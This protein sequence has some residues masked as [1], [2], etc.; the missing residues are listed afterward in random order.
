MEVRTLTESDVGI[1]WDL[2]LRALKEEPAAF[3]TSYT[4]AKQRSLESVAERLRSEANTPDSFTLG[5]FP[6]EQIAGM[7]G[8][9][10][11]KAEK[12]RHKGSIWGMYVTP[13]ARGHGL[14]RALMS[15]AIARARSLPDL[16]QIQ[17]GVVVTQ[18]AARRLYVSLGFEPFGLE[19][20]AVKIGDRYFDE[21]M[22]ALQL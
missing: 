7:V 5:A 18:T 4:E 8:F 14:G 17:L 13:E 6:E 2:R 9:Y 19:K 11:E 22:M 15:E 1:Y 16:E 20:R 10:R 21:E 12:C 3:L